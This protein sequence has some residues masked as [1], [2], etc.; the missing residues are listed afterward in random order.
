MKSVVDQDEPVVSSTLEGDFGLYLCQNS[1][2]LSPTGRYDC[3]LA[4]A[5]IL[6]GE[7]GSLLID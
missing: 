6:I 7:C 1:A 2:H 3:I 4:L 5:T